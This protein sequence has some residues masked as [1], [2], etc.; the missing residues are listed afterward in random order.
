MPGVRSPERGG[1]IRGKFHP[2]AV[3]RSNSRMHP[4]ADTTA[5]KL[6]RGPRG[7]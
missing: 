4:T 6:R 2:A 5:V 7:G 1:L 3:R